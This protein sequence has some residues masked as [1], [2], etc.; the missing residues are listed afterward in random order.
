MRRLRHANYQ[1]LFLSESAKI[2]RPG[3]FWNRQVL[4]RN[5]LKPWYAG[6]C[7]GLQLL[8]I[9]IKRISRVYS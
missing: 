7:V 8:D 3:E 4:Q 2:P 5:D 1:P 6:L 9:M